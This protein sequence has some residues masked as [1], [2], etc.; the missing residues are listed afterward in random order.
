MKKEEYS[1][2]IIYENT[3]G[4]KEAIKE[5]ESVCPCCGNTDNLKK[6]EKY[7]GHFR[8]FIYEC[9]C[10]TKWRGNFYNENEEVVDYKVIKK[11]LRDEKQQ[12]FLEK[13]K[14]L[15]VTIGPFILIFLVVGL[16]ITGV[17][18]LFIGINESLSERAENTIE[19]TQEEVVKDKQEEIIESPPVEEPV[20]TETESIV[21]EEEPEGSLIYS[22]SIYE[23]I[24]PIAELCIRMLVPVMLVNIIWVIIKR[25]MG[26]Y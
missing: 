18:F 15:F 14:N 22:E 21:S 9:D 20:E 25:L 10:G 12:A 3:K 24:L 7:I 4:K 2:G 19:I 1:Y 5:I 23:D 8:Q 26:D 11:S 13:I 6:E 16:I 17:V